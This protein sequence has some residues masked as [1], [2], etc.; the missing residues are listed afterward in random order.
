MNKTTQRTI[1]LKLIRY[2]QQEE[3]RD[4]TYI[5]INCDLGLR[6]EKISQTLREHESHGELR[7]E[8]RAGRRNHY[9]I[10]EE[11]HA[12]QDQSSGPHE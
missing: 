11:H 7:V 8:R 2:F 4:P 6:P 3:G 9:I 10:Q 1:V 5:D 12:T